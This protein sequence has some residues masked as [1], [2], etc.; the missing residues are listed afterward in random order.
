M[1][2][3]LQN[4]YTQGA[5]AIEMVVITQRHSLIAVSYHGFVLARIQ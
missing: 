5:S 2:L 1:G 3:K 4:Q